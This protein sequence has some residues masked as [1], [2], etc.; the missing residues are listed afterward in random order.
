LFFSSEWF[1]SNN[2]EQAR[3]DSTSICGNHDSAAANSKISMHESSV[4]LLGSGSIL[5]KHL[6]Y[7]HSKV[8]N[9]VKSLILQYGSTF[10][11]TFGT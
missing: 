10:L 5:S 7:M 8:V 1:D 9:V 6:L 3:D 11:C 2:D 4:S